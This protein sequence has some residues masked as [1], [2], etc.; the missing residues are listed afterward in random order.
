MKRLASGAPSPADGSALT[1]VR[2]RIWRMMYEAKP[3]RLINLG[4]L[5]TSSFA[6]LAVY[7]DPTQPTKNSAEIY[8]ILAAY[9]AFSLA[10]VIVSPRKR[11]DHP[12][13][14]LSIT[15][16]VGLLGILAIISE[17]LDSPFFI[18]FNFT[19]IIAAI[20]WGWRGVLFTALVL[21]AQTLMIGVPD[22]ETG[23]YALN[24]LIIRSI[25]CWV[26]A[27]MLGYFG[28]YRNR[29]E[30]RL[31]A[32]AGWPHDVILKGDGPWVSTSL[33]H[34]SNVF[35]TNRIA[36]LWQ[37]RDEAKACIAWWT[38]TECRFGEGIVMS[39]DGAMLIDDVG[40]RLTPD[41]YACA[42]MSLRSAL[43][44]SC[45][46]L[47]DDVLGMAWKTIH[48][49]RFESLRY[50]GS[51]IVVDPAFNDE[52][53]AILTKIV[54]SRIAMQ[55][56]Q[57]SL[58]NDFAANA[59]YRE[60]ARLARDLHDSVLQDLTAAV[61]Q[62]DAAA[63]RLPDREEE[64]ARIR[65]LLK[66]QQRRIRSFVC[67][68]RIQQSDCRLIDQLQT[69]V[70]PLETQWDCAITLKVDPADLKVSAAMAAELCLALSEATANA[71]R[72]GGAR[73]IAVAILYRDQKLTV[74]ISDDG[75]RENLA[76]TCVP[77]SLN[78]RVAD[79]GG[80][81]QVAEDTSGY[82]LTMDIPLE[83]GRP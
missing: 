45:E 72:H 13:H 35:E 63:T 71:V 52:D 2:I 19:L 49:S 29:S 73:E 31:R 76:T 28:S 44:P 22:L 25:Y 59:G 68:A 60:R 43:P 16:D 50:R 67:G 10:V 7:L 47:R 23:D 61:L 62:L 70:I 58:V 9:V 42:L 8:E 33:R 20:R 27:I 36:V 37:D 30:A 11:L 6:L 53:I 17:Q 55:L 83:R 79:L 48:V 74:S 57:F 5:A 14:A 34:A 24:V 4:R 69:L 78:N 40:R 3:E 18:F 15:I 51:V 82:A 1:R 77:Y 66:M 12:V 38:G 80:R 21:Q 32:L 64:L 65:D 39:G 56:E 46:Q 54:A 41:R 26:A 75:L 81:L